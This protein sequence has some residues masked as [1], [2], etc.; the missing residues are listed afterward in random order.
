[1]LGKGDAT[2]SD[3]EYVSQ[4]E[5]EEQRRIAAGLHNAEDVQFMEDHQRTR[6][7][8]VQGITGA[9]VIDSI[10]AGSSVDGDSQ[11]SG[12]A[13]D[14]DSFGRE[15]AGQTTML[16]DSARDARRTRDAPARKDSSSEA[17]R[18]LQAITDF[19]ENERTNEEPKMSTNVQNRSPRG[20]EDSSSTQSRQSR[21][22]GIE[23]TTANMLGSN[24]A[25][26][27]RVTSP[28]GGTRSSVRDGEED[29]GRS[30]SHDTGQTSF[31]TAQTHFTGLDPDYPI[32]VEKVIERHVINPPRDR[33]YVP[34]PTVEETQAQRDDESFGFTES[35]GESLGES[36]SEGWRPLKKSGLEMWEFG[37][38]SAA[39]TSNFR[40]NGAN[41]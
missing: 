41:E 7:S 26:G 5:L 23:E 30:T 35:E 6:D 25:N 14:A 3:S 1:M 34:T 8:Y 37:L 33:N 31:K 4:A 17:A 12:Q 2:D 15:R 39:N 36:R 18:I 20:R 40:R 16:R 10:A 9:T 28:S 19:R 22:N 13:Y 38:G 29:N 32:P 27:E 21:H 24:I 11:I